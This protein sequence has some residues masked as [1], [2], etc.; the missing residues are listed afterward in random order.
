MS[1]NLLRKQVKF[2]LNE[3]TKNDQEKPAKKKLSER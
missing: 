2:C 1:L 3:Y